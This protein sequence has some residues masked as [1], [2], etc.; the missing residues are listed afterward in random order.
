MYYKGQ[1][2]NFEGARLAEMK[3][4]AIFEELL[5]KRRFVTLVS[6]PLTVKILTPLKMVK[7]HSIMM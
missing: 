3:N 2:K 7:P 6:K 4:S 5:A 1:R